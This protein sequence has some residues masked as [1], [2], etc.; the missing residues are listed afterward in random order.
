MSSKNNTH[1][2]PLPG[3]VGQ[4]PGG[5]WGGYQDQTFPILIASVFIY[6]LGYKF[7]YQGFFGM[8]NPNIEPIFP[9][10]FAKCGENGIKV[11]KFGKF[12]LFF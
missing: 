1:I 12:A 5:K 11:G 7:V 4:I 3:E 9:K 10:A 2:F 6:G 8:L